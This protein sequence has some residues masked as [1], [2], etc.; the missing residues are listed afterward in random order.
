M[1]DFDPISIFG[2]LLMQIGSRYFTLE[3]TEA[4]IRILKYPI[5]QALIFF[6]ILYFSTRDINLTIIIF[7]MSYLFIYILFNENNNYNILSKIWLKKE[8]ILNDPNIQSSKEIYN[9]NLE[10]ILSLKL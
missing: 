3:L 2:I 7:F 9:N 6:T 1:V 4:Q 5:V 10:K 8:G